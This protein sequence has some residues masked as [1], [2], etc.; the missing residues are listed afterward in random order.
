MGSAKDI[1][2]IAPRGNQLVSGI[3]RRYVSRNRYYFRL[4]FVRRVRCFMNRFTWPS[5]GLPRH[6]AGRDVRKPHSRSR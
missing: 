5:V 3:A 2:P 6:H 1:G 4:G